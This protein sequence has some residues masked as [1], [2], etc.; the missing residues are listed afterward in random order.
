M[1][2]N[3]WQC[4]WQC[5]CP[6]STGV[7]VI[8]CVSSSVLSMGTFLY[9]FRIELAWIVLKLSMLTKLVMLWVHTSL[10][11]TCLLHL[12]HLEIRK[13]SIGCLQLALVYLLLWRTCFVGSW[14]VEMDRRLESGSLLCNPNCQFLGISEQ[15][16]WPI[17]GHWLIGRGPLSRL[18]L[19][20]SCLFWFG[21]LLVALG[22]CSLKR[23]L[24]IV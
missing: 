17:S 15:F 21:W 1:V 22:F 20:I 11:R 14:S 18:G 9:L 13:L 19:L 8:S 3:A 2:K 6:V 16:C 7:F 23:L 24:L 5:N 12:E 4:K 10:H